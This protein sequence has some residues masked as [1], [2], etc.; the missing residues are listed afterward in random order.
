MQ[1]NNNIEQEN[2]TGSSHPN[3]IIKKICQNTLDQLIEA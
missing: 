3:T 2:M 1:M